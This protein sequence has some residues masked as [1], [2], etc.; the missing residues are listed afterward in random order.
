MGL[1]TVFAV[2]YLLLAPSVGASAYL[3]GFTALMAIPSLALWLW[4]R[5]RGGKVFMEL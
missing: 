5:R 3:W 2:L 1:V 4:L